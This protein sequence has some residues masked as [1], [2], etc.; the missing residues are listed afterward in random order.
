MKR[1]TTF[2]IGDLESGLMFVAWNASGSHDA[3]LVRMR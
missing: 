1:K 3:E 2:L